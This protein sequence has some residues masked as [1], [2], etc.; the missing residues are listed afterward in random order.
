MSV[1]VTNLLLHQEYLFI[2][3]IYLF[4][5]H[6]L[7][8]KKE[9]I[10][11]SLSILDETRRTTCHSL[12]ARTFLIGGFVMTSSNGSSGLT[13]VKFSCKI[14]IFFSLSHPDGL[15]GRKKKGIF[16]LIATLAGEHPPPPPLC[17]LRLH[18]HCVLLHH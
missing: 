16:I 6:Q 9:N 8:R 12:P 7:H 1:T 14:A 10:L 13:V 4:V 18:E 15:E 3:C 2:L 11:V 17:Q 5:M